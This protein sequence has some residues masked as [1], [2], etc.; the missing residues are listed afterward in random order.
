MFLRDNPVLR[1]EVEEKVKAVL[2][3]RAEV[4]GSAETTEPGEDA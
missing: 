1:A 2:G 3:V 4:T